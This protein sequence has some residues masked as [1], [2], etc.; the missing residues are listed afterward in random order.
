MFSEIA[1]LFPCIDIAILPIDDGGDMLHHINVYQAINALEILNAN[2]MIPIH[3]WSY[4]L[5]KDT[6]DAPYYILL[7]EMK[8]QKEINN[9]IIPLYIVGNFSLN[10]A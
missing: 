2:Y 1:H 9:R 4:K 8:N 3:W 7:K 6:I 10:K 5:A